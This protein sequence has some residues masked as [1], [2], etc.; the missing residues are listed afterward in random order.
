VEGAIVT[1]EVGPVELDAAPTAHR[2]RR[3]PWV[4]RRDVYVGGWIV[5][6]LALVGIPL[7]LV[8]QAVSPR[9]AGL[10]LQAGAII[11]DETEAF[12]GTDGWFAL[13][14][15][16]AGLIA[17]LVVWTRRSWRGPAA[18]VALALGGVVGAL[19]TALVGHLTGGGESDGKASALIT[20]PVSLHAT[21]LLFLESAVAVLV[22][23]LLVAFTTRDDLG[24]TESAAHP[25]PTDHPGVGVTGWD[26]NSRTVSS[27]PD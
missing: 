23:G 10:V 24:R 26:A 13:L 20:L 22:Y 5:A 21:G 7:G 4:V 1:Q 12:I 9:S 27:P 11:P 2:S 15:A 17:A 18:V 14:T 3:A 25:Q 6:T 19:V 16:I 8:W